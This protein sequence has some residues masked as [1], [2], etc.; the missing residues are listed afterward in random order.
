MSNLLADVATLLVQEGLATE[1]STD[2]FLDY[3]PDA[4][5]QAIALYE[6]GGIPVGLG[7]DTQ[8]R[9]IQVRVRGG[10]EWAAKR[11]W[12]I[13][14]LL[15][16]PLEPIVDITSE[17]WG[18]VEVLQTPFILTRDSLTRVNF[19]FNLSVTTYSDRR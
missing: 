18:I 10:Y 7:V 4:P 16:T 14:N 1:I 9:N 3:L 11:I 17:R 15:N 5:D 8:H 12:D 6:Y 13:Y 2:I 19:A